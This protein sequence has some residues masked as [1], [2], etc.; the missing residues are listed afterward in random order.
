[1]PLVDR[2]LIRI[3]SE[4]IR[5]AL[6]GF[7]VV[8]PTNVSVVAISSAKSS[9]TEFAGIAGINT[10]GTRKPPASSMTVA[11]RVR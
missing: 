6:G 5:S 2:E 10:G 7:V 11:E 8:A 1:M 9:H 4:T 3:H